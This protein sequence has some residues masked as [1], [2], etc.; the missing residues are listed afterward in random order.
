MAFTNSQ[1]ADLQRKLNAVLAKFAAENNLTVGAS[2]ISYAE[3]TF[4]ATVQF[5]DKDSIGNV[6]PKY[7]NDLDRRGWQFG[8]KREDIGREVK[9]TRG[10]MSFQG[11]SASKAI[12]KDSTGAMWKFDPT[13]AAKLLSADTQAR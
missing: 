13:T 8:L 3:D 9:T 6:N 2:K 4:K 10:T 11:M 5:G 12:L 1:V 7:I